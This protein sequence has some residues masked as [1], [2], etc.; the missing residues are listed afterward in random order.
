MADQPITKKN[1]L[2][3][4][5][6]SLFPEEFF[7]GF[8]FTEQTGLSVSEDEKNIFVEAAL[9][10]L[11]ADDIHLHVEKGT[12][13][14]KG[15]KQEEEKDKKRKYYRKARNTFS[16]CLTLPESVDPNAEPDATF[17]NGVMKVVFPKK[18]STEPRRI[19]VREE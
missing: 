4:L 2:P 7:P 12:L 10:G 18:E 15:E 14:V 8:S 16:Y 1:R 11:T 19:P 3:A 9:P 13:W 17:K 5:F 6:E